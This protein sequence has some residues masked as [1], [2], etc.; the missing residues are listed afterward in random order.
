LIVWFIIGIAFYFFYGVR[1]SN[2]A[3][4]PTIEPKHTGGG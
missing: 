1:R 2:L 4:P 3:Q